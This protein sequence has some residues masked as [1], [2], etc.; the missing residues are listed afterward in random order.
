LFLQ[1][2]SCNVPVIKEIPAQAIT[3]SWDRWVQY[4]GCFSWPPFWEALKGHW[5]MNAGGSCQ[6]LYF[7]IQDI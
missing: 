2:E 7:K 6:T 3:E 5:R 1:E 4:F